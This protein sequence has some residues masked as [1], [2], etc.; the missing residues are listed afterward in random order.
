MT[1]TATTGVIFA[2]D[3]PFCHGQSLW[4]A[5]L[6]ERLCPHTSGQ[7]SATLLLRPPSESGEGVF[8]RGVVCHQGGLS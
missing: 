1:K 8:K 5:K 7:C 4:T 6:L 2:S 3:W